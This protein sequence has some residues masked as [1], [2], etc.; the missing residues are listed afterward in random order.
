MSKTSFPPGPP[1]LKGY[2]NVRKF[3]SNRAEFMR[4]LW[5]EY[6]DY[7]R[8]QL[9]L[10]DVYMIT[11]PE[12]IKHVL[13][14]DRDFPKTKAIKMFRF[15]IGDGVL[16]ADGDDHRRQRRLMQPAFQPAR[17]ATY[18]DTMVEIAKE[19]ADG[20]RDSEEL[21]IHREMMGL[22]L[23]IAAKTLF[24]TEVGPMTDRVASAIETIIPSVDRIAQ[25]TEGL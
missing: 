24:N 5:E 1:R 17:T 22:T 8:F 11:D 21:E 18:A 15:I 10:F 13:T 14:H 20:W 16:L 9:G 7:V 6:G 12:M 23:R 4:G 3:L 25:P 19:T 2:A